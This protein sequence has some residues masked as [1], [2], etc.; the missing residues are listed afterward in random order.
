VLRALEIGP[1]K[2]LAGLAKKTDKSVQVYS[3]GEPGALDGIPE[4]LS[5]GDT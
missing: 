2:V 3:V 5:A 4:F 1:E